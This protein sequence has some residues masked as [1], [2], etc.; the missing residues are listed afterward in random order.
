MD[1]DSH[2]FGLVS[3]LLHELVFS[4]LQLFHLVLVAS[5]LVLETVSLCGVGGKEKREEG[6]RKRET[7]R[8]REGEREGRERE[9]ERERRGR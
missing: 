6:M 1:L 4:L 7:R 3:L 8:E 2:L 9:R 5:G